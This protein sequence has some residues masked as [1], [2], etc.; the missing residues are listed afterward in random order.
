MNSQNY[1]SSQLSRFTPYL[2]KLVS[3]VHRL[4]AMI[5]EENNY[6]VIERLIE[7]INTYGYDWTE[8]ANKITAKLS[9]ENPARNVYYTQGILQRW[10]EQ[11][12][13]D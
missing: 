8:A 7:L 4:A 12:H 11:G 10:S 3:S 6:Q 1:S 2:E 13:M 5:S 9:G